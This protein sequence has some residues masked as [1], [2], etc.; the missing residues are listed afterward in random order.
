MAKIQPLGVRN[1][2]PFNLI[3]NANDKWQGLS[4]LQP[5]GRFWQFD[6]AVYGIR[7]GMR[8]LI[9]AQDKHG[10]NTV[11]TII[12][13]YAPPGENDTPAYIK[14]V[15][16]DMGIGADEPLD[17][18]KFEQLVAM[19][20]AIIAHENGA[21]CSTFYTDQQM[22]KAAILAGVEPP[23]RSLAQSRQ[24]IGTA[25]AGAA[26]VAGPAVQQVQDTLQP[27]ADYAHWVKP[28]LFSCALLGIGFAAWAK[29]DERKKGIS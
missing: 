28:V 22:T 8:D 1:N 11:R 26:T 23:R 9:T 20:S 12:T 29:I 17:M 2:N 14:A 15:S 10:R 18:H 5:G 4:R 27:W 21:P 16:S 13:P 7:A 24:I 3:R 25:I 6:D 19:A